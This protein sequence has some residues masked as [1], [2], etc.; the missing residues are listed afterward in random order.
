MLKPEIHPP[1]DV[2]GIG[3]AGQKRNFRCDRRPTQIIGQAGRYDEFGTC[4]KRR[5]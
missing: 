3:D 4:R 1:H 5:V 2:S